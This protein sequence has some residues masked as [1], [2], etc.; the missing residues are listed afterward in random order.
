MARSRILQPG[1]PLTFSQ[2]FEMPFT[3]ED[4]LAEFDCTI[5]RQLIELPQSNLSF[6]L[7]PL[8]RE[9]NRNRNR[10]ELVNETARR[11]ALISPILFEVAELTNQR[12]NV[13]YSIAV[14]EHLRGTVDYYIASCNLAI[15]EAK[16]ADLVRGFTQLAVELVALDQW[17]RSDT[18]I[19]YGMVTTGEDWR[20]GT[21]ERS[22][23]IVYQDPRRYRVPEELAELVSI[24]VGILQG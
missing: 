13:E 15:I 7:E 20:F 14:N 2:Y 12:I 6:N 24:L 17:T 1:I 8:D 4:I 23:G 3:I 19:L 16:Q 9:L 22:S 11:E 5:A 10:I 21:F 18:P